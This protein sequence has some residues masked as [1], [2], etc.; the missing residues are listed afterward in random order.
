MTAGYLPAGSLRARHGACDSDRCNSSCKGCR[1]FVT[2]FTCTRQPEWC[3]IIG[4]LNI[5]GKGWVHRTLGVCSSIP[6]CCCVPQW[7]GA[8]PVAA[9]P[10]SPQRLACRA[11]LGPA[12]VKLAVPLSSQLPM[13]GQR[14]FLALERPR[15]RSTRDY[16]LSEPNVHLCTSEQAD[17]AHPLGDESGRQPAGGTRWSC[18]EHL[19][20]LLYQSLS[21][22][23]GNGTHPFIQKLLHFLSAA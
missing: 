1:C 2:S 22:H 9:C 10:A 11:L 6:F 17:P 13:A 12:C 20:A 23:T 3:N 4:L 21:A 18:V 5:K 8:H 14:T 19:S 15:H 16:A 7:R